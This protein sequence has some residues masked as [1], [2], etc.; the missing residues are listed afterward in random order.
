MPVLDDMCV[1]TAVT[2]YTAASISLGKQP[3]LYW[4]TRCTVLCD[5]FDSQL[6]PVQQHLHVLLLK[7]HGLLS[8]LVEAEKVVNLSHW[9]PKVQTYGTSGSVI[10]AAHGLIPDL[11]RTRQIPPA[12]ER[13][14]H[15]GNLRSTMYL[16]FS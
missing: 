4:L 15:V 1:D 5:R 3:L 11:P 6:H 12:V 9:E 7:Q 10:N 13:Q 8:C 16:L 2:V 14:H